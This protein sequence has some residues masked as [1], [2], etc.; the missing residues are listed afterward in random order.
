MFE[1]LK[2]LLDFRKAKAVVWTH[3]S[4]LGDA[5]Y[6]E[7]GSQREEIKLGQLC[8]EDLSSVA[9]AGTGT[10]DG[11]V[12]AAHEWDGDVQIMHVNPSREESLGVYRTL[13]Q[14]ATVPA[15]HAQRPLR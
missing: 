8:R 15:R 7:M 10:H 6:T 2:R 1:T 12:A 3:N 13:H 9:L 4:H 14:G 5:R 11:T